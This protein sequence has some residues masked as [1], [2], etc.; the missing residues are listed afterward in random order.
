MSETTENKKFYVAKSGKEGEGIFACEFI[1]KGQIIGKFSGD[2]VKFEPKT[3]EDSLMGEHWLYLKP[4]TWLDVK[5][6]E[7]Y[8]NHS[9]E[10]NA[11]ISG[12]VTIKALK[13]IE[14]NEEITID[15]STTEEDPNWSMVCSCGLPNCRK[16]IKSIQFLPKE[17]FGK[18]L[19]FI[20]TYLKKKYKKEFVLL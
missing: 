9:C 2:I 1:K 11:G 3:K 17:Q 15:Y 10:P 16:V 14:P 6:D 4:N 13:D 19:P 20:P 12:S 18:Y 8:L 5:S 7:R